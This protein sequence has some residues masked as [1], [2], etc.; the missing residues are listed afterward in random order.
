MLDEIRRIKSGRTELRQFGVLLA[1]VVQAVGL[2]LW[3]RGTQHFWLFVAALGLLLVA[4]IVPVMLWPLHK[5]W[6]TLALVLGLVMS[7][8]MLT[9]LFYLVITPIGLVRRLMGKD[10]LALKKP[11]GAETYWVPREDPTPEHYERQF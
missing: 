4:S 10:P 5:V 8:L 6:M 3:W 11:E 2:F 7:N 9:L 1:I